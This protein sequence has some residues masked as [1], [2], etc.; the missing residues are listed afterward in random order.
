VTRRSVVALARLAL[1]PL[2]TSACGMSATLENNEGRH[3]DARILGGSPGSVYL[4]GDGHTRF[5]MRRDD[6]REVDHPGNVLI[7]IG[8]VLTAIGG[9]RIA[10]GDSRCE[11]FAQ[12]GDRY[13]IAMGAPALA[14]LLVLGAGLYGYFR[15]SRAFADTSRPEPDPV[16]KPRPAEAPPHLPGW[17]KPDPFADPKP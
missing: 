2:A 5:T 6:V 13:C 17:R 15:S 7:A 11:D 3:V 1:L 9:L 4:A 10:A 12:S 14:G 16:V 8:S